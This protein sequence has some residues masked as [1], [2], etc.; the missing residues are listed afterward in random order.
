MAFRKRH[1]KFQSVAHETP[2]IPHK[3][4]I[5]CFCDQTYVTTRCTENIMLDR[6]IT[7]NRRCNWCVYINTCICPKSGN[8]QTRNPPTK[9]PGISK[10][11]STAF[12]LPDIWKICMHNH[13]KKWKVDV[14]KRT[15]GPEDG[16]PLLKILRNI[17]FFTF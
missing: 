9:S 14:E 6:N 2:R 11:K 10:K 3:M 12:Y 4:N 15:D 13:Q 8:R 17:F 1:S 5:E 7:I 16:I